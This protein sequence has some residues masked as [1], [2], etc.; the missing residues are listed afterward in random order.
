VTAPLA[1]TGLEQAAGAVREHLDRGQRRVTL[2]GRASSG[3]TSAMRLIAG[4][5]EAGGWGVHRTQMT[6]DDDGAL[7]ALAMLGADL[8]DDV[9]GCLFDL[10]VPWKRKLQSVV[11]GLG[12][13]GGRTAV[14]VDDPWFGSPEEA[15]SLF[16]ERATDLLDE[17]ER[18]PSLS[19]V[20]SR[21]DR[22]LAGTVVELPTA[23]E[24]HAVLAAERWQRSSLA[25]VARQLAEAGDARLARLSPVELRLA[26]ALA[27][28]KG[29]NAAGALQRLRTGPHAFVRTVLDSLGNARFRTAI[30]RLGVMRTPFDEATLDELL[31]ETTAS[32]RGLV[33]D[34]LLFKTDDGFVVP[35]LLARVA[36]ERLY[37]LRFAELKEAHFVAARFHERGFAEQARPASVSRAADLR[38]VK[39]HE[40]EIIHHLTEAG[41]AAAVFSRSVDFVEQYD[42]LGKTL[43]IR[44][45]RTSKRALLQRAVDAYD[46]ALVHDTD[47]PYAHHYRAYN[48]DVL[49][50]DPAPVEEGYRRALILRPDHVWHHG[51]FVAFLVTCGR[52]REAHDAWEEALRALDGLR[53][54]AWLFRELHRPV[55]RLLLHRGRLEFAREVLDDVPER[56]GDTWFAPARVLLA[57]LEE[58][59]ADQLVFPASVPP[60]SRWEGP[61]LLIA[62]GERARVVRWMPGRIERANGE[63]SVRFAEH[64]AKFGRRKFNAAGFRR[65][66]PTARPTMPPAGTFLEI[67]EL[68]GEDHEVIR[69]HP[70][71]TALND[72][73]ALFPHPDRYL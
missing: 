73:P 38:A 43:S 15:P 55:A 50:D 29:M 65:V 44:G 69:C 30:V 32:E 12:R 52:P 16:A 71:S 4:Q 45:V 36:K 39:R 48:L 25:H 27:S 49:A 70:M 59:E 64:A 3:K 11:G 53:G 8:G 56:L 72:L 5:L 67:I 61:H 47:D 20:L 57:Q 19:L 41:D 68:E 26:V 1:L 62:K 51:R 7:V 22:P 42:K 34:A 33:L 58:A 10:N 2:Y 24:P 35:E 37:T 18:T 6:G 21:S 66:C 46:R 28:V 31:G 23:A 63:I 54:H 60:D 40:M 17:I 13:T 14:L 9:R